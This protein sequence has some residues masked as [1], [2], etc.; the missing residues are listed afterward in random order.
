MNRSLKFAAR[1]DARTIYGTQ[2]ISHKHPAINR[3]PG[4]F[5][6]A[7]SCPFR[8]ANASERCPTLRKWVCLVFFEFPAQIGAGDDF[9]EE[10]NLNKPPMMNCQ[11]TCR[12]RATRFPTSLVRLFAPAD[13][14]PR[15]GPS[16]PAFNPTPIVPSPPQLTDPSATS[17]PNGFVPHKAAGPG[18][19][20]LMHERIFASFLLVSP[21]FVIK[22]VE[23]TRSC[24]SGK[25]GYVFY[26]KCVVAGP[27][28]HPY[29]RWRRTRIE[30]VR[31][32][33]SGAEALA[34]TTQ[35]RPQPHH[36]AGEETFRFPATGFFREIRG[37]VRNA[38]VSPQTVPKA[39]AYPRRDGSPVFPGPRCGRGE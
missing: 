7:V 14:G 35:F 2:P 32:A 19:N 1:N 10:A 11:P 23:R 16:Q 27:E 38:S 15:S 34:T 6:E 33:E 39:A 12:S 9:K 36:S 25:G 21:L 31:A 8:A 24:V 26:E 29:P 5:C 20:P 17:T 18:A 37:F 28:N 13:S 22:R 3:L 4:A 30:E